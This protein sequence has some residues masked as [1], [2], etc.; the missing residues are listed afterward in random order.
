MESPTAKAS[1]TKSCSELNGTK[2]ELAAL[3]FGARPFPIL[4]VKCWKV[5][6]WNAKTLLPKF[7]KLPP[8]FLF[9]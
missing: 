7:Q 3:A 6:H 9:I 5:V 2:G 1:F 8:I 4:L